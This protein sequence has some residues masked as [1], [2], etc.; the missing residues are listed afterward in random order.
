MSVNSIRSLILIC[1]FVSFIFGTMPISSNDS[2]FVASKILLRWYN[3][4]SIRHGLAVRIAGS[5]P[6]GPGSTPGVGTLF[7]LSQKQPQIF[8][9]AKQNFDANVSYTTRILWRP[10]AW[11]C[12]SQTYFMKSF[13]KEFYI[14]G[15]NIGI[16]KTKSNAI[17]FPDISNLN[18]LRFL[19]V[20]RGT[21]YSIQFVLLSNKHI[22]TYLILRAFY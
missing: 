11:E 6:A 16:R 15:S 1:K 12:L 5:H 2:L 18:I 21:V 9:N 8:W 7:L 19:N 17:S 20:L 3:T 22:K 13:L 10:D 14:K 4:Y